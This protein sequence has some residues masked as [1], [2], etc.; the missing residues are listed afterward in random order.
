MDY[1]RKPD[2]PTTKLYTGRCRLNAGPF[3]GGKYG[4]SVED[5][6]RTTYPGF[7]NG[8]AYLL[9]SDMVHKLV[10]MFDVSK[11]H[12]KLEDVYIGLLVEKMG[13]VKV[14]PHP[15]FRYSGGC[16]LN[17]ETFTQHRASV[18]CMGELFN[19]AMKERVEQELAQLRSSRMAKA[20]RNNTEH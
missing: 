8:P 12:F 7:C 14:R 10:E 18:Q 5:Y 17:S 11:K 6:N 19:M 9:S 3:R 13:D 20:G 4:V 2:T 15:N 16:K 1:L